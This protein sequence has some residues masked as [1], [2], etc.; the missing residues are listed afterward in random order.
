MTI[1]RPMF[2]PRAE[3]VVALFPQKSSLT[4]NA[5]VTTTYFPE[6][7]RQRASSKRNPLRCLYSHIATA[8]T[9]AGKLHRGEALQID[10]HF[11]EREWL[12]K[13]AEK[14]RLLAD[15]FARLV[16]KEG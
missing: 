5:R 14:A 2:P 9:I 13:G 15:E 4:Q 11:D 1:E 7:S 8:V 16:E 3:N 12:R 10:Q 6:T